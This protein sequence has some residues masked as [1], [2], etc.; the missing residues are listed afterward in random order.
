MSTKSFEKIMHGLADALA[1][2]EGR[3]HVAGAT[4]HIPTPSGMRAVN[5]NALAELSDAE[6]EELQCAALGPDVPPAFRAM[7]DDESA[8]RIRSGRA[9]RRHDAD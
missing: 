1:I 4:I 8:Q 3:G 2:S 9:F 6:F 5:T 7:I